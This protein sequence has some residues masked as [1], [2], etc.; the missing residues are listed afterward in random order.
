DVTPILS[1]TPS[2]KIAKSHSGSFAQ[3]QNGI[4]SVVVSNSNTTGPTSGTITVLESLPQG[5]TLTSMSGNG[6]N[7]S[8][9][10]C[11]RA[12]VL[13]T[14]AA[15]DAITVTVHVAIDAPA[16]VTNQVSVSGGGSASANANDPTAITG[17]CDLNQDGGVDIA[18]VQQAI[19]EAL[20][21]NPA[22]HDLNH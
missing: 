7:C 1:S 5:F 14:G 21:A 20:G 17:A 19:E 15:F 9:S 4:Y 18:D 2:L 12:D 13:A 11:S 22:L 6:W 3:G 10:Q 16:S 8:G